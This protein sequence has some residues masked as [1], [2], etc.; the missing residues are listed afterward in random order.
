MGPELLAYAIYEQIDSPAARADVDIEVLA[1]GK[2]LC[3][4][5]EKAQPG[6]FVEF[7]GSHLLQLLVAPE[8]SHRVHD[9][10]A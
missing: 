9:S 8:A 6:S 2:Q 7:L 3:D 4:L 1:V 10:P 5:S